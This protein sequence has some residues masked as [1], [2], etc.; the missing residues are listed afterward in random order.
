MKKVLFS[1]TVDS[2]ILHFHLPYLEYFKNNGYEVH[3]ATDTDCDIPFCDKK[4]KISFERSP[5]KINNLRAILQLKKIIDKEKFDIIHCH[6]PMGSV[7]TRLAAMQAR[8]KGTNVI[9]TAHGFHFYKG[10]P[11]LNWFLFYSVEKYLSKY[12]DTLITINEEDYNLAKSKFKKTNVEYVPGVGIEPKKFDIEITKQ[13]K[14]KLREELNL[15]KNDFV[16]IYPAE[17]SERKRQLWLI[18][19]LKEL[20]KENQDMHLLLPGKDSLKGE[21]HKL[22]RELN[23][24]KQ[25]HLLGYRTDIK[26]ILRISNVALSSAK[27]EGLPV[28]LMEAMYVGIPIVASDCR[29]NRDLVQNNKNGFI[30]DLEDKENF[31][32]KIIDIK[33]KRVNFDSIKIENKFLLKNVMEQMKKIYCQKKI[34]YLRSTS[35]TNDS[36]ATKTI[37]T[38]SKNNKVIVLGWNRQQLKI[39][40]VDNNI[41]FDLYNK[42]SEY[43]KGLKNI[44]NLLLF[45]IWLYLKLKKYRNKYDIIHACDFDT[46]YVANK[47]SKKY[48]KKFIYDIYDYYVD[49]HNLSFLSNIIE[50][51]D[52]KT[53]NSADLVVI[54]TEQRKKQIIKCNPKKVCVIHNSPKIEKK[55]EN[56]KYNPQ[57][58][59]I[60]YVGI[61]QDDRLLMEISKKIIKESNLEFHI[62]GFGKYENYFQ[63]LS[64]KHKNIKFYGQMKYN[65]VLDLESKCDILFATYNPKIPN[66]KF[67]APNKV[68]EAMALGK[69][70][71]VCKNTGVDE[72]VLK[73]KIGL[74]IEY[75]AEEFIKVIKD[76]TVNDYKLISSNGIKLYKSK[77]SWDIMEQELLKSI[78]GGDIK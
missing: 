37:N 11:L 50:K 33:Q 69:P 34:I 57:K 14:D 61:L 35:I 38:Y 8:K 21:C 73:E 10:A 64:K 78:Q 48:N 62:G 19:T 53:I 1:A 75:D 22:V 23:L 70:I 36:R 39:N 42:K 15:S 3:V 77:Y 49:C 32:K 45:Q 4:H 2:H 18:D 71:V 74:A 43:G 68:Y 76:I 56:G 72:L 5:F 40:K 16:M 28:N 52:I 41:V 17:L 65:E 9:Y 46:A 58:I 12:T 44:F 67:S 25:I 26:K 7:V 51:C 29:G 30:I 54:C 31:C 60:C 6:T 66:H 13:D 27:Q 55:V 59:K 24:E 47:V 63:E 20:L